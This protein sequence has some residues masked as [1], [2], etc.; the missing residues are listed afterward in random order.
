MGVELNLPGYMN[1][2]VS[3][4]WTSCW[5]TW[6]GDNDLMQS[7]FHI[8]TKGKITCPQIWWVEKT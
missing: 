8:W 2:K 6:Q 5:A 3:L 7:L 4:G 1:D